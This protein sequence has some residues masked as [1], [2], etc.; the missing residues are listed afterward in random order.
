MPVATLRRF[1]KTGSISLE[2]F[3][4][5]LMV[6]GGL[7]EIIDVL[8]PGKPAFTSIDEVLKDADSAVI[9]RRGRKK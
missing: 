7:E 4:K 8:K 6:L 9:K 1:E 5:L 2:S 3:L